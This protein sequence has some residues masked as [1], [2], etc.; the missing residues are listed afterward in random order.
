M[1]EMNAFMVLSTTSNGLIFIFPRNIDLLVPLFGDYTL[2]SHRSLCIDGCLVLSVLVLG[3]LLQ[4]K[5][6]HYKSNNQREN[7]SKI[8]K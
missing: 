7:S 5:P 8:T 2:H 4:V 1:L 3:Y 6:S